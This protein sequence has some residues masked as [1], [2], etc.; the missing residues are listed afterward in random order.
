M[1][2][3]FFVTT[4]SAIV[5]IILAYVFEALEESALNFLDLRIISAI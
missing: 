2:G 5:A 3:A 1:L 4:T